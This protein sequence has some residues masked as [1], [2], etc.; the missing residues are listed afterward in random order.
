MLHIYD[1]APRRFALTSTPSPNKSLELLSLLTFILPSILKSCTLFATTYEKVIQFGTNLIYY[2]MFIKFYDHFFYVD[3][4]KKLN[5]N[6][7]NE[8]KQRFFYIKY[9]IKCNISALQTVVYNHIQSS[10]IF[11]TQD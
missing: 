5:H 10:G 6:L 7:P 4:K 2:K 9:V 1:V 3:L 8:L 11:L